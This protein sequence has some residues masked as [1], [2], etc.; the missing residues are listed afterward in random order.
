MSGLHIDRAFEHD[1]PRLTALLGE[2]FSIERDFVPDAARQGAGLK[3]LLAQPERAA[4]LVARDPAGEPIGM[5][6]A[7]LVVS[8]AE[9]GLSAGVVDVVVAPAH[10]GRGL[11]R[12]LLEHALAWAR[13]R[14]AT[15]A[16]LLVDTGNAPALGFYE[17]LG[18]HA[19]RLAARR[20]QL[21]ARKS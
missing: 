9:G 8:T 19:T 1:V 10:R 18:W 17:A 12:A 7:Q 2:L 5:A 13:E 20:I 6:T 14:G 3:L 21:T 11:G 4:V 15:R 16:Q